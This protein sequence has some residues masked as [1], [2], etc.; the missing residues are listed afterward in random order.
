MNPPLPAPP[1]KAVVCGNCRQPMQVIGLPGHYGRTVEIDVCAPCHLVWFDLTE[2]ARLSGPALLE[3]I[4]T[5]ARAQSLP[6]E[7][8]HAHAGCARCGGGLK[9]VHNRSRWGRSLQLE[10]RIGHGAYQSFAEFL[11]EKGAVDFICDRRE[12][13]KT[14]A[15]TLAMLQRMPADALL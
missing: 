6:H 13:R 8:L 10:C 14:I 5:M 2:T 12:L 7:P 15:R 11:Q 4:G 9:T 3:L 1:A